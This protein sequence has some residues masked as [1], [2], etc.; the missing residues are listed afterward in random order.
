MSLNVFFYCFNFEVYLQTMTRLTHSLEEVH[1]SVEL[2]PES[3]LIG[4]VSTKASSHVSP[5]DRIPKPS[6]VCVCLCFSGL[7]KKCKPDKSKKKV[8]KK[9]TVGGYLF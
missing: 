2:G 1:L 3:P 8:W 6:H 9:K 5:P 7:Q 4:K